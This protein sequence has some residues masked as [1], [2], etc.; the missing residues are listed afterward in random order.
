MNEAGTQ[1]FS[2]GPTGIQIM[3]VPAARSD[4]VT[5]GLPATST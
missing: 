2:L 5:I 1:P 3:E 4:S